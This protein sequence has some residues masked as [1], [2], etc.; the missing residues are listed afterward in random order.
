MRS[1]KDYLEEDF[2]DLRDVEFVENYALKQHK[3]M[4]ASFRQVVP[5]KKFSVRKKKLEKEND[6]NKAFTIKPSR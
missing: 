3:K 6:K 5:Q 2:N 4:K 1:S